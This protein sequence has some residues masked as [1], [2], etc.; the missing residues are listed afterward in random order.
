MDPPCSVTAPVHPLASNRKKNLLSHQLTWKCTD[1][2]RKTTFLLERAFVHFHVVCGRAP[3]R[4]FLPKTRHQSFNDTGSA[5]LEWQLEAHVPR[6]AACFMLAARGKYPKDPFWVPIFD[7]QPPAAYK[8]P[9]P[10]G[11][12]LRLRRALRP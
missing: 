10:P 7:A 4:R 8:A 1:P 2:C 9:K 6:A 12:S 11:S 3:K 5:N